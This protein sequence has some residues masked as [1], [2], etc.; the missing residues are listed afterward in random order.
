M[1][2]HQPRV[3]ASAAVVKKIILEILGAGAALKRSELIVTLRQIVPLRGFT[4]NAGTSISVAKK[5]LAQLLEERLITSPRIGWYVLPE[6]STAV[7]EAGDGGEEESVI[8]NLPPSEPAAARLKIDR[9]I[10]EGPEC[11]YVYFHDVYLE[12]ARLK[13]KSAWEC[14]VG[15]TV[16]DPDVRIMGQGALTCFPRYPVIGLVIRTYDGRNLE[17]LLHAALS[18]AGARLNESA[19]TEW[20]LTSPDLIEQWFLQFK[21]TLK[22]LKHEGT[23]S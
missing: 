18:Y 22:V 13:A 9:E 14:K 17:R 3:P 12:R 7:P 2:K 11:V 15:W 1:P 10:G 8:E 19:G 5:A 21:E 4:F 23:L 6:N 20:F 16:G